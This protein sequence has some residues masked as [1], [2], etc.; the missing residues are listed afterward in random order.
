MCRGVV[1]HQNAI[2][3]PNHGLW[4]IS[5]TAYFDFY[6][7]RDYLLGTP[8]RFGKALDDNG[9]DVVLEPID[10]F[11]PIT[12]PLSVVIGSYLFQKTKPHNSAI[13]YPVQR[14]YLTRFRDIPLWISAQEP[15]SQEQRDV[16]AH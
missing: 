16:S 10:P 3:F 7:P 15:Q 4:S 1:Y 5:P 14:C 6:Q 11:E 8:Y 12:A 13:S 9:F 2:V